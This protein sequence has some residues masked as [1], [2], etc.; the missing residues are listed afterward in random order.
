MDFIIYYLIGAL[1]VFI[2]ALLFNR[3]SFIKKHYLTC[4]G[5]LVL[6]FTAFSWI[7]LCLFTIIGT[8]VVFSE[9]ID[10]HE[11]NTD[12]KRLYDFIEGKKDD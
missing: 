6:T 2:S 12:F 1:S 9:I 4:P 8:V 3:I 7:G 10:Y 5:D 11:I